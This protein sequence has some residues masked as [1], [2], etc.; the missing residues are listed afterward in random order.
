[1]SD[2]DLVVL[3]GGKTGRDGIHGA[4]LSSTE[5]T[6]DSET[7][8]SHAVQIGNAIQE[9]KTLDTLIAARDKGLYTAVTDCGAGGLSS[10]V[11]EMG[12]HTGAVVDLE[13]VPLKYAGLRPWEIWISEAQERMVL[14][15]PPGKRDELLAVFAS[16]NVEATVIGTFTGN[17][18]LTLRYNGATVGEFDG[19]F[20]HGGVPRFVRTATWAPVHNPDPDFPRPKNLGE[21]LKKILAAWNVCSKEWIV[22]QYDHEVQAGS[23]VKPLTGAANDG[24]S[25][26]SVIRPKLRSDRGVVIANGIN[27]KYGVIDPYAMALSNI[28]EALRNVTCVGSDIEKTALLDNF[29][30]GNTT[31]P[32][33][34][35]DLVRASEGCYDG[36]KG[37]GTPFISGKDSLRNEFI[38]GD[39]VIRIPP[40]LL[41]SAVAVMDDVKKA[42]TMDFKRPGNRI[43][44]VGLTRNELG[45]SHYF[46]LH[47]AL[48]NS[49]PSVDIGTAR[50]TMIALHKAIV[51]GL[52]RACHDCSEGGIGVALA[53]MAFAGQ[54]GA[55][56]ALSA[57]PSDADMREDFILFSESNS[58]FIVEVEPDAMAAF[59]EAVKGLP[60]AWIGETARENRLVVNG[61]A[62]ALVDESLDDLKEAWKKPLRSV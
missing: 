60:F 17:G 49:V 34:L 43:G 36:A 48:G 35:G 42:V 46:E 15:V 32:D 37:F 53:E 51:A 8:S 58:R 26:A 50:A 13:K 59:E 3:V 25:D 44:I 57:I 11:G 24:P 52:V 55:T 33:R 47:G 28:D 20:L 4:T 39:K 18:R 29:A 19:A 1:M 16:E 45:G 7:T 62:G 41:I 2:G 23:V 10:A 38:Y 22:R 9:K 6:E 54:V 21:P 56:V 61:H 12:E 30:W 5:V 40:T 27:P 14:S 31:I